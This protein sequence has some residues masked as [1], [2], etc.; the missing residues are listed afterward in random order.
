[1]KKNTIILFSA[2]LAVILTVVFAMP[3]SAAETAD[4]AK[5]ST[6]AAFTGVTPRSYVADTSYENISFVSDGEYLYAALTR[7]RSN[8]TCI[9]VSLDGGD[10]LSEKTIAVYINTNSTYGVAWPKD[11]KIN[12]YRFGDH[13]TSLSGIVEGFYAFFVSSS[14]LSLIHISEPTRR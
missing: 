6:L 8:G 3:V 5:A 9:L 13:K 2:L 4:E 7:S 14:N 1:M 11:G 10:S 12:D